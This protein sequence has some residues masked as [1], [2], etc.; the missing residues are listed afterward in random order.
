MKDK[1]T[2]QFQN[3]PSDVLTLWQ[4]FRS[5][6]SR[7]HPDDIIPEIHVKRSDFKID[8]GHLKKFNAI[9]GIESTSNLHLL[10]PFTLAYPYLMRILCR[11]EMPFSQF[12]TLNTRNRIIMF[13]R[14]DPGEM[15]NIDCYNSD[16]RV[17]DNGLEFDFKAEIYSGSEKVWEN[18]ATYLNRGK[19]KNA[20]K[21]YTPP[22]LE[23][24]DNPSVIKE[25]LFPAENRYKF[26]RVSGDTNGIHYWSSYAR[27]FGFKRDFAQPIRIIARCVSELPDHSADKPAELDFY[28]KG[29]VY[30]ESI[31]TLKNRKKDNISRFDLYCEGNS[32]PCISARLAAE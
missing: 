10:Y 15:L 32:R 18:T 23:P 13:R 30:Y 2:L 22:K 1:I 6:K 20:D 14:V 21:I 11:R 9:C 24:A 4:A 28:L 27:M 5:R 12:K 29:P 8:T 25:W 7:Y 16:S 26:G 31:L 17:T 3:K 19:F